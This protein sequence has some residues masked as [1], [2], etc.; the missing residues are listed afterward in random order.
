MKAPIDKFFDNV[1]VMVEDEELR[2]NRLSILKSISLM[3]NEFA[4][5]GSIIISKAK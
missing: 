1:M 2:D 3:M 4:D 5:L